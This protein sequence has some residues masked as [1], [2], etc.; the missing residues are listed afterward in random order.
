MLE[1]TESRARAMRLHAEILSNAEIAAVGLC[2]MCRAMK[3]MRDEKLYRELDCETFE[4]YCESVLGISSRQ[5]YTYISTYERLG[6]DV[7]TAGAR[8][9]ITK[10]ELLAKLPHPEEAVDELDGKTT[11][12]IK[13][14]VAQL[15]QREEQLSLAGQAA[16]EKDSVIT[17]LRAELAAGKAERERAGR[18]AEEVRKLK[19]ELAAR[20]EDEEEIIQTDLT[21]L[22]EEAQKRE[23][24]K[25]VKE[26]LKAERQKQ[27]EKRA[28]DEDRL[29]ALERSKAEL[30]RKLAVADTESAKATALFEQL[31]DVYNKLA[32]TV[33]GIRDADMRGRFR[34]AVKRALTALAQG[35]EETEE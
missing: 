6:P 20:P 32:R 13:A 16:E 19:E 31:Q 23:I 26:A 4:G 9:G 14:L 11:A 5:A 22:D 34:A 8:H 21:E 15:A 3:E 33:E 1:K 17:E 29:A 10:L 28:A 30:E 2:E 24:D 25:A 18:L 7:L 27:K 35:M 12:E